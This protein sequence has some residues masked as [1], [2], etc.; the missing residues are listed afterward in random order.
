MANNGN[1]ESPNTFHRWLT[2]GLLATIVWVVVFIVYCT[3]KA[4]KIEDPILGNVFQLLT[5]LWIGTLTLAQG[6][7]ANKVEETAAEAKETAEELEKRIQKLIERS[8]LSEERETGWSQHKNHKR[9]SG[10]DEDE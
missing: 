6:K 3:F 1:G 5:G 9:G 10:I 4:F 2:N 7:K 8:K